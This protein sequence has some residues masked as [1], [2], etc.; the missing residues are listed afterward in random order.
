VPWNEP[1][2]R[3]YSTQACSVTRRWGMF[4]EMEY[5]VPAIGAGTGQ[6]Q[7]EEQSQLWTFRGT[8]Q[9]IQK[10]ARALMLLRSAATEK[11]TEARTREP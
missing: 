10:I 2:D 5:H 8:R 11:A 1:E 3:G 6:H 9:D 4:S 7:V